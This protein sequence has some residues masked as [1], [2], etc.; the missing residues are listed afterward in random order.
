VRPAI[1]A[2]DL[3]NQI[4]STSADL[5][6]VHAASLM[7]YN[8]DKGFLE[9]K[10]HRGL[11]H[12]YLN[13]VRPKLGQSIEG[14]A[15][16]DDKSVL[17]HK[18]S[19]EPLYSFREMASGEGIRSAMSVP[20]TIDNETRGVLNFYSHHEKHFQPKDEHLASHLIELSSLALQNLRLYRRE[21]RI[22]ETLQLSH[23]PDIE[24]N[25]EN[26]EIAHRYRVSMEESLLGGDFYD[27]FSVPG[28]RKAIV[29]ADVSGKGIRAAASTAMVKHTLRSYAL[30]DPDPGIVLQLTHEAF[31]SY[32]ESDDFVTI[33]YGL[34]DPASESISYC[35][36]G[37]PPA[38]FF[39][40]RQEKVLDLTDV[41]MPVGAWHD[42]VNYLNNTVS[43]FPGDTLLVYTDGLT[44]CREMGNKNGNL[45][46][47]QNLEVLFSGLATKQAE[48]IATGIMTEVE[49]FCHGKMYDDVAF[50]VLKLG[51]Q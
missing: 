25:Y 11:S 23:F 18:M 1:S 44:D 2:H 35:S 24:D 20:F 21:H 42:N 26:W 45:F 34:I 47:Q 15:V 19:E 33:F 6:D 9:T 3:Y 7:L 17:N 38:L 46:G 10:A 4:L 41:F 50:F 51:K 28:N 39:S 14:K 37:H 31:C 12:N 43:F 48:T 32:M 40:A 16:A 8:E 29:V 13:Q 30:N 27:M 49:S 36:A 5:L 22:A